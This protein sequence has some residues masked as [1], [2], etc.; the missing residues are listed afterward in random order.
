MQV[1]EAIPQ[2]Y[3]EDVPQQGYIAPAD[4]VVLGDGPV[5]AKGMLIGQGPG[6]DEAMMLVRYGLEPKPFVGQA[7]Q[8]LDEYLR[9]VDVV[10]K[11]L[12]ITN[13]YKCWLPGNERPTIA[14]LKD[15]C[16]MLLEE[17]SMVKPEV[18][19]CIGDCA[20]EWITKL[21][22]GGE[23]HGM[24]VEHGVPRWLAIEGHE[25]IMVPLYH[26]AAGLHNPDS[27]G[28]I[29]YDFQ[30]FAGVMR[31]EIVPTTTSPIKPLAVELTS[32]EQLSSFLWYLTNRIFVD[33]EGSAELPWGL[34]F[35]LGG[36]E[37]AKIG[38]EHP[39][40]LK[41]FNKAL[42]SKPDPPTVVLHNSL[43]DIPVLLSMGVDVSDLPIIDT[44]ILAY[45]LCVEPQGLKDLAWRHLRMPMVEYGDIAD[46]VTEKRAREYLAKAQLV[47]WDVCPECGQ[48]NGIRRKH[49]VKGAPFI[50]LTHDD[51]LKLSDEFRSHY[52][53]PK[54]NIR[55]KYLPHVRW[56]AGG[57]KSYPAMPLNRR[58]ERILSLTKGA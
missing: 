43:H 10:R 45:L 36:V 1:N 28:V 56:C 42:H 30:V 40:L 15:H 8:E 21:A 51:W 18:V 14:Q 20:S 34:T 22:G 12:Y 23:F 5:P 6:A 37:G 25:F 49:P 39:T 11:E 4:V 47:D 53:T 55:K 38:A 19:G 27:M 9:Q 29:F 24:D 41:E 46:P 54:G 48:E 35:S 32:L 3:Q 58:I 57:E 26:P 50:Q 7:G 31:E 13:G 52:F 17:F 33:T 16:D 44:M 2:D